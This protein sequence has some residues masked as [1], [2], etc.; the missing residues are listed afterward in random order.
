MKHLLCFWMFSLISLSAWALPNPLDSTWQFPLNYRAVLHIDTTFLK[1]DYAV[2]YHRDDRGVIQTFQIESVLGYFR[3]RISPVQAGARV[4]FRT[5]G[6]HLISTYEGGAMV[7]QTA[8]DENG[9]GSPTQSV[10]LSDVP[11]IGI[12]PITVSGRQFVGR[13]TLQGELT[14]HYVIRTDFPTTDIWIDDADG[15]V[16]ATRQGGDYYTWS[17]FVPGA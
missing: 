11:Q 1:G 10:P 7:Q 8:V 12:L 6:A 15:H 13:E 17:D 16:V 14:R 4:L 9:N 2:S 5:G 3:W